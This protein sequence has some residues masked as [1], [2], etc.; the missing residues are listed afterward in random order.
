MLTEFLKKGQSSFF[1]A[2]KTVF[3]K[4]KTYDIVPL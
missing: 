2:F 1:V 3:G 4:N